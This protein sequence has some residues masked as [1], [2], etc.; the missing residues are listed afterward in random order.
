M[1]FQAL[2]YCTSVLASSYDYYDPATKTYY[3][4]DEKVLTTYN[5]EP[6]NHFTNQPYVSNGYFGSRIPNLGFGFAYDQNENSSSSQLD[7][8]WPLFNKR[9]AG[10]YIAGFYDAQE[11]TTGTNF[12]DLLKNGYESVISSIPQWTQMRLEITLSDGQQYILDPNDTSSRGSISGYTQSLDLSTG[13]VTTSYIWLGLLHLRF[14]LV[15]HREIAQL[16]LERLDMTLLGEPDLISNLQVESILDFCSTS[17]CWLQ[18]TGIDTKSNS[19]YMNVTPENVPYITATVFSKIKADPPIMFSN[20]VNGSMVG[21]RAN[22]TFSSENRQSTILKFVGILS[23]DLKSNNDSTSTFEDAKSI[24]LAVFDVSWEEL[25]NSNEKAWK[26]LWGESEV[27][28]SNNE[29]MTLA[30]EASIFHLLANTRTSNVDLTSALGVTGLSSD[31]YAGM[32][33]WDSDLWMLPGILPFAPSVASSIERYRYYMHKQAV[34]NAQSHNFNGSVYPW[35]SGRFGN[36]TAT[37]PCFNYEYHIN[38]AICYAIHEL[39][40]SGAIDDNVLLEEGWPIFKDIA[41][42]FSDY[43]QFN[44]TLGKF[45][46]YNLTDPDEYAN[47]VNNAAYTA[48]GIAQVMKWALLFGTHLHQKVNPIWKLIRDNM[49]LPV[50]SDGDITLEY[51]TLNST[52]LIKQADVALITYT[53]DQDDFLTKTYNYTRQRAYNDLVY[54]TQ[55]QSPD[56]PAMSYP[57]YLAVNEKLSNKGCG[58]QTYLEQSVRPFLRFPFAQMSEQSNDDYDTNGGTHPA[59][60]FLTGHGG[61]VQSFTYGLLGIRFSYQT[62]PNGAIQRVLHVDPVY[63]PRFDGN[64]TIRGFHYLNEILDIEIDNTCLTGKSNDGCSAIFTS[65]GIKNEP[66]YIFVDGR[67]NASGLYMLPPKATLS[68]PLFI[69]QMNLEGALTECFADVVSIT[70]GVIGDVVSSIVDGDNSTYWQA[71]TKSDSAKVVID[72]RENQSFDHGSI[73]W[74]SRP[75]STFSV[76]I[77]ENCTF[78]SNDDFS[79]LQEKLRLGDEDLFLDVET[80]LKDESVLVTNPYRPGDNDIKIQS[81]NYTNFDLGQN[82]TARYVIL[83][84]EGVIDKDND[85]RGAE[86]AEVALF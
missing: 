82:Y 12:P 67:N 7:A 26:T 41:D 30:A 50:N 79:F 6:L 34:L 65:H 17:R 13:K 59:F 33:F 37:G 27:I 61:V 48:I 76:S 10:A 40:L 9:N 23:D 84:V 64:Y 74:G 63:L 31:G 70:E 32:A 25:L 21:S 75:A 56:G 11:N 73:V 4:H 18:D 35:T 69:P 52:I 51:D 5:Y 43:V 72:L 20:F 66:I 83:E 62:Q 39:Y 68:V 77:I 86:I 3:F 49:Y 78:L 54:Y 81:F 60:P 85:N 14:T 29:Y 55:R 71:A 24:V 44:E 57:V 36:C 47:H 28:V 8:G 38:I 53:D 42:F 46:T 19:I 16:G 22:V 80:I 45:T 1:K 15:A 58:Y 2:L